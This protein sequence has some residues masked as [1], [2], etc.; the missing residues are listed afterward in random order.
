M[1][2]KT[3]FSTFTNLVTGPIRGLYAPTSV[4][5]PTKL[6]DVVGLATPYAV[7]TGWIDF[8]AMTDTPTY[9]RDM[10]SSDL[11]IQNRTTPVLKKITGTTRTVQLTLA[12]VTSA[13]TQIIENA[14]APVTIAV[15]AGGSGTSAQKAVDLGSISSLVRYRIALIGERDP[16][17]G[18]SG[19]GGARGLLLG[20]ILYSASITADASDMDF[21]NDDLV[22]RP[23]TFQAYPEP[24]I[25]DP[26]KAHGRFLEETGATVP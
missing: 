8:G 24:T 6:D 2:F 12:E 16:G 9:G 15:G 1:P 21:P 14:P 17:L 19:E 22:G 20:F 13:L 10:D 11:T 4:S 18:S 5:V 26:L 3:D 25:S 7:K 23:V